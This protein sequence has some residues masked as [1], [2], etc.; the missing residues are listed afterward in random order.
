MAALYDRLSV[1][2]EA[3]DTVASLTGELRQL[4][5]YFYGFMSEPR[6]AEEK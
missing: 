4:R 2:E 5:E 1:A 3:I 6:E